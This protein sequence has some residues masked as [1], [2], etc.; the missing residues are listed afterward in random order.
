MGATEPTLP[1]TEEIARLLGR[2]ALADRQAFDALYSHTSSKLFGV[3]LRLLKDRQEAEDALQEIYVKVWRRADRYARADASPMSWLI[4]VARN[5]AIDRLRARR[6]EH[7]D[8]D[9]A[10]NVADDA[11]SPEASVSA[12]SDKARVLE[13]LERLETDRATAVRGAYLEGHSYQHLAD[14]FQI[15]LNTMRTWLR[16]SLIRLRECLDE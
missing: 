3:V 8:L 1:T 14:R 11:P 5:H 6:T 13:C 2:V 9:A 7:R 10:S 16:R 4:A 15:P 12:R